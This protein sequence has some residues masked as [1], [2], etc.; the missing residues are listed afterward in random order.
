MLHPPWIVIIDPPEHDL[1]N[2]K[3]TGQA[4]HRSVYLLHILETEI[5]TC[6]IGD[7]GLSGA[8]VIRSNGQFC[9][10]VMARYDRDPYLHMLPASQI[11]ED[12]AAFCWGKVSVVEGQIPKPDEAL[13]LINDILDEQIRESLQKPR[14][15]FQILTA[16]HSRPLSETQSFRDSGYKSQHI[17]LQ[18]RAELTSAEKAGDSQ[19][20]EAVPDIPATYDQVQTTSHIFGDHDSKTQKDKRIST[21]TETALGTLRN[22]QSPDLTPAKHIPEEK[23]SSALKRWNL[24]QDLGNSGEYLEADIRRKRATRVF[25]TVIRWHKHSSECQCGYLPLLWASELDDVEVVEQI[26]TRN[27]PDLDEMDYYGRTA[28]SQAACHGRVMTLKVLLNTGKVSTVD[29]D[30]ALEEAAGRGDDAIVQMLLETD[31]ASD[32][33]VGAALEVAVENKHESLVRTLLATDKASDYVSRLLWQAT[34]QGHEGMVTL[35]LGTGRVS[36]YS[37][38][39][40]LERAAKSGHR[41]IVRLLSKTGRASDGDV[42]V[43]RAMMKSVIARGGR[44]RGRV[45]FSDYDRNLFSPLRNF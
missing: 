5:L 37:I 42:D 39:V 28:F 11:F 15:S 35:L 26:L 2:K 43:I 1:Q 20:S 4:N 3:V 31:R 40:A 30:T 14:K 34:E 16:D 22:K 32:C 33:T 10:C 24:A 38:G 21:T 45:S 44:G 41:T 18:S 13:Q 29:I 9:G 27:D 23:L 8:W 7:R 6:G 36:T 12:I 25:E 17:S 19:S